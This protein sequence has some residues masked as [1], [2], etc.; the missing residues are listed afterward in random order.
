MKTV[1]SSRSFY[2]VLSMLS[3]TV[4]LGAQVSARIESAPAGTVSIYQLRDGGMMTD[5]EVTDW[6]IAAFQNR[7]FK[8]S[9]LSI[10]LM[11]EKSEPLRTWSVSHAIPKKWSIS[12]L[13][14]NEN[15]IVVETLELTYRFFKVL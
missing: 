12:D 9:D 2:V 13:N 4:P 3:F 15:S 6:C 7:E 11:N 1:S 10:I 8:P 14:S 5:S